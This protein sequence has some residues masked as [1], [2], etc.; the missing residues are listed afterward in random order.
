MLITTKYVVSSL[1]LHCCF[2]DGLRLSQAYN[3]T[4][5]VRV[6]EIFIGGEVYRHN[7]QFA[8]DYIANVEKRI[9]TNDSLLVDFD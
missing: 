7:R 4:L 2:Y 3:E 8:F 9:D 5:N 1:Q 6:G